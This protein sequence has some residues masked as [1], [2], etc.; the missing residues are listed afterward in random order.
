MPSAGPHHVAPTGSLSEDELD[1]A[2]AEVAER[3]A[4][5]AAQDEGR[6]QLWHAHHW[7]HRYE[8]C[9]TIGRRHVCRRCLWFYSIAFVTLFASWAGMSPWPI[10]WDT[11]LV[12]LLS[13]PATVDFVGGE[14]GRWSYNATRQIVV[15]SILGLAVGRGFAAEVDNPG[16]WTFWGPVLVFG[17]IWFFVATGAWFSDRGQYRPD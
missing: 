17:S 6:R 2:F 1:Q 10:A 15:T 3:R 7:P 5:T 13:I 16:S 9:T 8:R 11:K 4:T 12:W 14:I